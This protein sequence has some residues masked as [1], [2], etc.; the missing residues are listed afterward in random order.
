MDSPAK[1]ATML[2]MSLIPHTPQGRADSPAVT[3]PIV[4]SNDKQI[5]I[6]VIVIPITNIIKQLLKLVAS[7][8]SVIFC[9]SFSKFH[10]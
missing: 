5:P 10:C 2:A 6:I 8:S 3:M 4:V 9:V 1:L 7:V